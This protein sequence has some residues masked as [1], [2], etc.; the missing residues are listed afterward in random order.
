MMCWKRSWGD[1][2]SSSRST[3][4]PV[5]ATYRHGFSFGA[6]R[7]GLQLGGSLGLW[8]SPYDDSYRNTH[9]P[10]GCGPSSGE[11]TVVFGQQTLFTLGMSDRFSAHAGLKILWSRFRETGG[12]DTTH[13][14]FTLGASFRF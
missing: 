2:N 1:Y 12:G 7:W 10:A 8:N 9:G 3:T 14:I 5:L 13:S 6:S 11:T 4:R